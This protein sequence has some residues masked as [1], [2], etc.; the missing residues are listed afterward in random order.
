VAVLGPPVAGAVRVDGDHRRL[1]P[2]RHGAAA[3]SCG[4]RGMRAGNAGLCG[5]GGRARGK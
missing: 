1:A 4:P 3:G 5:E 2:P